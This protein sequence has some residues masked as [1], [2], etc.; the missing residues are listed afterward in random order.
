MTRNGRLAWGGAAIATAAL[1]W[2]VLRERRSDAPANY[3]PLDTPKPLAENVWIVDSGPINASGLSLPIRMTVVR[4]AN[5]ELLLHSPTAWSPELAAALG[6]L[7]DVRHLIAPNVA[8]WTLV[9]GWQ[10]AF[11]DAITWGAPGLRARGAVKRARL[12][13]DR[14]LTAGAPPEWAGEIAQGVIRGAAGFREVW[15][16]HHASRTLL[17]TDLVQDMDADRLPPLTALVARAS[18][19][20]DGTTPRY[21]RPVLTAGDGDAHRTFA[22]LVALEP[23]QVVF[24]HGRPFVTGATARLRDALQWVGL[25]D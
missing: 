14:D 19:G 6:T 20:A 10:R 5:G 25:P 17:L 11:P 2:I 13:I 18:G 24:A 21:L 15:F 16:F 4:L 9:A 22:A 23:R 1:A 3:P 8:H 12:R 7:G